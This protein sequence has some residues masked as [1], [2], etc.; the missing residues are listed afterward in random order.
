M[1]PKSKKNYKRDFFRDERW[2]REDHWVF[3][4]LH[5]YDHYSRFYD[6]KEERTVG[7][8]AVR[9]YKGYIPNGKWYKKIYDVQWHL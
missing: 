3:D 4:E 7:N 1:R 5:D 8:K 6:K 2:K 9:R